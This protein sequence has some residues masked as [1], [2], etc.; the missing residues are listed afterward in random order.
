MVQ[1]I[2]IVAAARRN[3]G[4]Q[5]KANVCLARTAVNH[6][7]RQFLPADTVKVSHTQIGA[8]CLKLPSRNHCL[9]VERD[10]ARRVAVVTLVG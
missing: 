9:R 5:H 4:D 1:V 3:F 8:I 6:M 7:S 10:D 2:I